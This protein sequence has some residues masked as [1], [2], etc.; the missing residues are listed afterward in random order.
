MKNKYSTN[1]FWSEED[2]CFI[3]T[4]SEFPLL[5]AHG[6]TWEEAISE[7]QLVLEMAIES[8]IEDGV[9]LPKPAIAVS[10]SGQFRVRLPKGLHKSLAENA[11]R[12]GV[13]LNSYVI[14][15]ISGNYSYQKVYEEKI[16]ALEKVVNKL[17]AILFSQQ[18]TLQVYTERL[19][20]LTTIR[21]Q[22]DFPSS[23]GDL[24]PSFITTQQ[25][26]FFIK[27]A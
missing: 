11:E 22:Q 26:K 6:D 5:S 14:A 7:F 3:A 19:D 24:I 4:C 2:N 23:V 1:V 27:N 10:H 9:E 15:L 16:E 20:M 13:S 21:S 25:Q 17:G 8:F 18:T 12:D